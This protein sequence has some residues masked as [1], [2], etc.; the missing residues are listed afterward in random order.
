LARRFFVAPAFPEAFG[1]ST[2]FLD[3]RAAGAC[4]PFAVASRFTVV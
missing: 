3:E 2:D 4:L 1:P